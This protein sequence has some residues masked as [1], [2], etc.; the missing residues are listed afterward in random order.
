MDEQ[1]NYPPQQNSSDTNIRI[2]DLEERQKL[3]RDRILLIGKNLLEE[4]E[5]TSKTLQEIKKE[6]LKMKEE[7][8]KMKGFIQR[9]G[10]QTDKS[11]SKEDL[12]ILQRQFDLFRK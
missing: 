8:L 11:A 1:Y 2:R 10:E 5:E 3:I 4:R 9:V 6:V 12:A 7:Q